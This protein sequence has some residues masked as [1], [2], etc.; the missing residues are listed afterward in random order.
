MLDDNIHAITTAKNAGMHTIG[1]YD[2][3]SRNME[4][5]MRQ[6]AERY[7]RNFSEL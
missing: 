2:D 3:S 4:P 5:A 6:T 1:V 7:I